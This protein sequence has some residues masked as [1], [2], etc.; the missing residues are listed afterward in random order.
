MSTLRLHIEK[1]NF[2]V[3]ALVAL[4]CITTLVYAAIP[5]WLVPLVP[6]LKTYALPVVLSVVAGIIT[7]MILE[8]Q[9]EEELNE[10]SISELQADEKKLTKK[11]E[12]MRRS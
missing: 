8:I 6:Y 2:L 3:L 7:H 9:E 4:L 1:R 12:L 11:L 5:I 10:K